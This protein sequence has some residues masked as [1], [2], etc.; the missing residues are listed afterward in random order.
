MIDLRPTP[1][2]EQVV[3][4]VADFLSA[5]LP[6]ERLLPK[7]LSVLNDDR[8]KW[9]QMGELGFFGLG[10]TEEQGGVGYTV[11]EEALISREFGRY[12]VSPNA[13]ATLLGAHVAALAG[14]E[15]LTAGIVAGEA[16]VS[17]ANPFTIQDTDEPT[18]DHHLI[19][20]RDARWLVFWNQKGA[21]L[22][23]KDAFEDVREV[24]PVDA[25]ITLERGFLKGAK[26]PLWV[27]FET[28]DI[29]RRADLLAAAYLVGMAEATRDAS[30]EYAK[31][32]EQFDQKIGSFQA[33]K[34]RCA[35]MALRASAA[36]SQTVFA[37]LSARDQRADAGF[38]VH[39]ARLIAAEGALKNAAVNIHNHG[40]IGFTGENLAHHY[41]KRGHILDRIGGGAARQASLFLAQ[42]GPLQ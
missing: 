29:P 38:H 31:I 33:V 9:A 39:A 10:L 34:H 5:E 4:S 42:G 36:W 6:G 16:K 28:D 41:L 35:D 12:L 13:L 21:G 20:A 24:E 37:A 40:G 30:V 1:E 25:S 2:Q 8:A 17:I 26:A 15:T 14:D 32:R 18:G 19:D 3:A 27:A 7:P 22:F 23:P 11:I